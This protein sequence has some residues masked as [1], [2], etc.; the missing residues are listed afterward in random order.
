[1]SAKRKLPGLVVVLSAPSGTGKTTI[2]NN[3]VRRH[4]DY[5]F[6]ISVTTRS[7][8]KKEREGVDYYFVSNAKFDSMI[9]NKKL[10]E[11][12]TVFGD[13]Y[14]TP[15]LEIE[16]AISADR[17]LLC[18]ID[19]Q[20]GM[21][22]KRKFDEAVGIFLVPPS[23]TELRCRLFGR[24]TDTVEQRKTRLQTAVWELGFWNRYDYIVLNDDL[25]KATDEVDTIIA[26]ERAKT[27]R[28]NDRRFWR[29]PQ[30][31]L[32]GL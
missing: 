20:G 11:W 17:V 22:L 26:A 16:K 5:K 32:L 15:F 1:M 3:L 10:A 31:R 12:A 9:K 8:R 19:V 27:I 6:S 21:S 30:A 13:R 29:P 25:K 18:D 23:M 2:C 24:K 7:P 14:G 4:R 28:R